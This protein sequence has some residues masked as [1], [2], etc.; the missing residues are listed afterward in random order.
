[1]FLRVMKYKIVRVIICTA[2][3]AYC[4]YNGISCLAAL[5]KAGKQPYLLLG[6]ARF[7]FMGYHMMAALHGVICVALAVMFILLVRWNRKSER[8]GLLRSKTDAPADY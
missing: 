8:E 5:Y 3:G 7:D 2:L 4:L 6:P 1:M